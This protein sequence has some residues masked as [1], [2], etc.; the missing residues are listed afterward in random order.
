M[1][2]EQRAERRTHRE[3]RR[4]LAMGEDPAQREEPSLKECHGWNQGRGWSLETERPSDRHGIEGE[5]KQG[6]HRGPG[7]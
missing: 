4:Q 1:E 6:G 5:E 3:Q 2:S 7:R